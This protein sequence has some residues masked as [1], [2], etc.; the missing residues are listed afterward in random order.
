[1]DKQSAESDLQLIREVMERS[2]RYTHFSGLSGVISGLLGL[3]GCAATAWIDANVPVGKH[4]PW[5]VAIWS[6][7]LILAAAEDLFLAQRK[8]RKSGQTIWNPASYQMAR[9]VVP[10]VFAALVLSYAVLH[11]ELRNSL[12]AIWSLGYGVSLCAAGM[13]S[14]KEVWRYGILQLATGAIFLIFLRDWDWSFYAAAGLSFGIY[15]ILFGVCIAR[16]QR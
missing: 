4:D 7:V 6:T 3:A 14:I 15:Q 13:F 8:A 2:V 11:T 12:S 1:M 9:A 16:K 5:Y 10:G